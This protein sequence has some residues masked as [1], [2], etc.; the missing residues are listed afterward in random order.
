MATMHHFETD[1]DYSQKSFEKVINNHFM[2]KYS[3]KELEYVNVGYD[4][5]DI[6]KLIQRQRKLYKQRELVDDFME[7]LGW[8]DEDFAKSKTENH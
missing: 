1:F 4:I 2:N 7:E 8:T 3:T 5:E 6:Y